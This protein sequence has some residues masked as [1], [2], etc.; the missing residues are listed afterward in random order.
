MRREAAG[1]ACMRDTTRHSSACNVHIDGAGRRSVEV[2]AVAR[3]VSKHDVRARDGTDAVRH[4]DAPGA[5]RPQP[6]GAEETLPP[7]PQRG[8]TFTEDQMRERFGVPESGVIRESSTSSDII[9]VRNMHGGGGDAVEGGRVIHDGQYYEGQADQMIL[10][11]LRLARSLE[12]GRRVLYFVKENG[13]LVFDGL[14]ECLASRRKEAPALP[15][16]LAF[17][18][19]RID[20]GAAATVRQGV[21]SDRLGGPPGSRAPSAPDLDM[22]AA[23]ELQISGRGRFAGRSELLAA[24]PKYVDSASL[25]RMPEY[26]EHS[27][28]ISTGDDGIHWTF[29]D[30]RQQGSNPDKNASTSLAATVAA[31]EPVY[32]LSREERRSADLDND[33]PYSEDIEQMIADCEAGRPIGRTYTAEEYRRHLKQELGIG[34]LDNT[35][36]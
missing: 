25:D 8:D 17:E 18:L 23:V 20:G 36:K 5:A 7:L 35:G 19:A 2:E 14:V 29:N 32:I 12:N 13:R 9:L 3:Q 22:I 27:A 31:E 16:A 24:L 1:A 30:T 28:K 21:R 11:N 15:G 4:R 6:S 33:L 34:A 26:L 10:G